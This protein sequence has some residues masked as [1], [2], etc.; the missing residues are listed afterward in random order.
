MSFLAGVVACL[1]TFANVALL[2]VSHYAQQ[3]QKPV[4]LSSD[5]DNLEVVSSYVKLDTAVYDIPRVP[6]KPIVNYPLVISQISANEPRRVFHDLT[7]WMSKIGLIYPEEYEVLV[8]PKVRVQPF[9]KSSP[10][11]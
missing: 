3:G 5:Y 7:T 6:P 9:V 2:L 11:Y 10:D 1:C 8:K 4:A